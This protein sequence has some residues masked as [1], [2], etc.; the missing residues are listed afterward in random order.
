MKRY[1]IV[2]AET[3]AGYAAYSPDSPGCVSSGRTRNEVERNLRAALA[4]HLNDL[5]QESQSVPEPHPYSAYL[6]LLP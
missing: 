5:R 1:L 6:E 4:L 3:G 2:I